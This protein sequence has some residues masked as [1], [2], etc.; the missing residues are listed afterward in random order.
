MYVYM[1][2]FEYVLM[3]ALQLFFLEEINILFKKKKKVCNNLN[4]K[5]MHLQ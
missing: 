1:T 2:A 3:T 5:L 4:I